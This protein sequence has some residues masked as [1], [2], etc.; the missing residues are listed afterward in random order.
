MNHGIEGALVAA[1]FFRVSN[2]LDRVL[3]SERDQKRKSGELRSV[4]SRCLVDD[5]IGKIIP[6]KILACGPIW[7]PNDRLVLETEPGP[8]SDGK[9]LTTVVDA[10]AARE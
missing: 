6:V 2:A 8:T 4:L 5:E 10:V 3:G 9:T 1:K 7:I